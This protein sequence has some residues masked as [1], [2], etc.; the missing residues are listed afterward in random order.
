MDIFIR[1]KKLTVLTKITAFLFFFTL[2]HSVSAQTEPPP[3]INSKL[4]GIVL[5]SATRQPL[6]G[7][8]VSILGTTHAVAT[9][10]KGQFSFVTG[11]KFPYTLVV[12]F[13]GYEKREIVA[14]GSPINILLKEKIS[15]LSEVVVT[16]GYFTQAKKS[17]TG[18]A[19][20]ISGADNANKP[21]ASPLN[22]L[23]GEV[24]GLNVV[25]GSSQPG[26]AA[27]IQLRG[28]GSIALDT[29]PLF[30]VDGMIVNFGNQS[31]INNSNT[32]DALAGINQNDIE[33]VTVL[34]D[35]SATAIYGSRGSNGVIVITTKK[36]KAGKTQVN[37]D[38]EVG[39][40]NI[41][42]FPAAGQPL[43]ASQFATLFIEGLKNA[44]YTQQQIDAQADSYGFNS[45]KSNNW[46]DL[47][48][49][50]GTQQQYNV[51][52]RSGNENTKVYTSA[53]YFK[54]QAT[55]IG[56]DLQRISALV[57]LDQKISNRINFT[58]GLN[59]SNV[60]QH[61]PNGDSGSWDNPIFAARIL[62]P[63]QLAYN[64]DG[65]LNSSSTGNLGYTAHY[66]VLYIAQNDKHILSQNRVQSN[67][68]LNWNIWDQLKY[69]SYVSVDYLSLEETQYHNPIL[70]R[71]NTDNGDDIQDYSHNFNWL[72]RNQ[73]DYR[74]NIPSITDFYVDA[75]AGYEAQ[76]Y[77]VY[78]LNASGSGYPL[79]QPSLTALSNTAT[80]TAAGA[81]TS[82]RTFNSV[83][84]RVSAN[85]KNLYS[86][87]GSY[88][89]DGSSVFGTDFRYGN[90][91]SI[92][93]AWNIDGEDFFAGQHIFSSA[94]LRSSYGTTGNANGIGY[95]SARSLASYGSNYTTGNGQNY[96]VVGN[97]DL[98]WESAKKFDVGADIG[99]FKD[100][101]LITAD[102]YRNLIDNLIQAVN[103]SRTTGF[104][105]V[106]YANIGAMQ[107]VGF[108]LG[109]KGVPVKL[110]HFKWT[111][112][113]N[114]ATNTN[115]MTQL[116]N[117]AGAH[118][119]NY[120]Q[121]GYDINTWYI[122]LYAGVNPANGEALWYTD[123][124]KTQTTNVYANA[125]REP[126]KSSSP[127]YFGGFSNTFEYKGITLSADFYYNFGNYILD[128][129]S[130]RFYDGTYNTFN[131]Y[132]REYT[133]RWTTPGQITD[134]PKYVASGGTVTPQVNTNATSSRFLY[135]GSFIR[136][137]N[138]TLGYDLKNLAMFQNIHGISKLYVYGRGTN[139]WTKTYDDKLPYDP[140]SGTLTIPLYRTFTLGVNVGF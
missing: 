52:V 14:D 86:I 101:L 44:G 47:V 110:D 38:S 76:R 3:T 66:N 39:T 11:Q 23:Q 108:E 105:T 58:T 68:T 130:T 99:F 60:Y 115:K 118:G 2:S 73:L 124:T 107:N 93:G 94:K 80:P 70:G 89:R 125:A 64:D 57:N 85:Y 9:N 13:V 116:G 95:Y 120:F 59:I 15:A 69:S 34:K 49:R 30:V 10:N 75:A 36:G 138:V 82:S 119:N 83:Y 26:A 122:P 132:Q 50:T 61:A 139:L 6:P 4:D 48:Y 87:S 71:G 29:N 131:K 109:I 137:R 55:T 113:F 133:N 8:V 106:P 128:A 12:S 90:F 84:S 17:Y 19:T 74:Y 27:Q 102:Y 91:W 56:S 16:D 135:N 46:Q 41:V 25:L 51:S 103:I 114:I 32:L 98:T 62:R 136:L 63:F 127:K 65:T 22:A 79:T 88:R 24:A 123:A 35:A 37:F 33:S 1:K 67:T 31:K 121:V 111:S 40:T 78:T 5:D 112:S 97:P 7:V 28:A 21:Y 100:R 43:N 140:E 96:N 72:T 20:T 92:G 129:W 42:P 54:Q 18:A 81:S 53:G 45:G 134:V 117:A 104:S 77:Q 126:D